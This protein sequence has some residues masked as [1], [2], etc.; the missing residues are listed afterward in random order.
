[1]RPRVPAYRPDARVR[2]LLAI[3]SDIR[4]LPSPWPG[5]NAS[6]HPL[7]AVLPLGGGLLVFDHPHPGR[8]LRPVEGAAGVVW[9][10]ARSTAVAPPGAFAAVLVGRPTVFVVPGLDPPALCAAVWREAFRLHLRGAAGLSE[11]RLAEAYPTDDPTA[12]ALAT[13]EGRLLIEGLGDAP[14]ERALAL[15]RR[16]R[17][18]PLED[19]ALEYERQV[20]LMEGLPAY[21][22]LR[23]A[24][25][26]RAV[27]SGP[28]GA[29]SGAPGGDPAAGP[30]GDAEQAS[31]ASLEALRRRLLWLGRLPLRRRLEASGAAVALLLDRLD[32][33]WK[34]AW[35]A[36]TT[37]DQLLE[38]H[39]TFDGGDGDEAALTVAQARHGFAELLAAER[40]RSD[41]ARRAREALVEQILRGEGSLVVVD[42]SSLGGGSV[43]AA[44]P[45]EAVNA[46][47]RVYR[48]PVSVHYP[49]ARLR[50]SGPAVAEDRRAGLF[51]VRVPGRLRVTGDGR[52]EVTG[53]AAFTS[54]L[55]VDLPGLSI[56]ARRGLVR[57]LDGGLYI[58]LE[59]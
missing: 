17:R 56:R 24:E 48:G 23:A 2:H 43:D 37:L 52:D 18:A 11:P 8:G 30:P 38:R 10:P 4:A 51:Q 21:V 50:F 36:G 25:A 35:A 3:L 44:Q 14:V 49:A 26:L 53:P 19:E 46:G 57:P 27:G 34:E 47:L 45:G 39:V 12:S 5:W 29:G 28:G 7:A 9:L 31:P 54:G 42:V 40:D 33:G 22:G 20:E 13:V 58:K 59:P 16:E 15:V 41:E 32:P 6:A 1:M 55:E